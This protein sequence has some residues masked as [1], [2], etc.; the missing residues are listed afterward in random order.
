MKRISYCA[1]AL[2]VLTGC[3][4]DLKFDEN[5]PTSPGG[6]PPGVT[7]TLGSTTAMVDNESIN[8]QLLTPA[9]WRNEAFGFSGMNASGPVTKII[10]VSLRLPGPGTYNTGE[11]YSPVISYFEQHGQTFYRWFMTRQQGSGSVTVSFL[12]SESATGYFHGELVPDSA[13]FAAGFVANKFITG[14]TFSVSVAR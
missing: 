10:A 7:T 12:S 11:F 2:A 13:T 14:G 3:F 8:A 9:I 5:M 6:Q 1:V 4:G